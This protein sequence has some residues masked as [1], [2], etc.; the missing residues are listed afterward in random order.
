MDFVYRE[1]TP[2][3]DPIIQIGFFKSR[4][5]FTCGGLLSQRYEHVELRFSDGSVTSITRDPGRVHYEHGRQLS[6]P[7]YSCFFQ[8]V[9]DEETEKYMQKMASHYANCETKRFSYLAMIWNF[10]PVTRW[11]PLDGLFCSQYITTLLKVAHVAEELDP[12]TTSPDHLFDSLRKHPRCIASFNKSLFT[13]SSL[14]MRLFA[15]QA[16]IQKTT[17]YPPDFPFFS[18]WYCKMFAIPCPIFGRNIPE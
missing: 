8:M 15:E 9:V 10:A 3:G 11:Y 5:T 14:S 18:K 4:Q 16:L 6:N 1:L 17:H 7:L 13:Y 12:R 2:Q